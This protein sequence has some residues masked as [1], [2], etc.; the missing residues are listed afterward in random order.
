MKIVTILMG[1]AAFGLAFLIW[2][3][4]M[5]DQYVGTGSVK[6]FLFVILL[7]LLWNPFGAVLIAGLGLLLIGSAVMP[8]KKNDQT[9]TNPA[10]RRQPSRSPAQDSPAQGGPPS[11]GPT[12]GGP[13]QG[14]P[15]R[16]A[17]GSSSS[18][19]PSSS[20]RATPNDGLRPAPNSD[21]SER[22]R[23]DLGAPVP[24]DHSKPKTARDQSELE[25][26]QQAPDDSLALNKVDATKPS[27]I[28]PNATKPSAITPNAITLSKTV[29]A[30]TPAHATSATT[31]EPPETQT[32]RTLTETERERVQKYVQHGL[33]MVSSMTGRNDL[34]LSTELGNASETNAMKIVQ[35]IQT[36]LEKIKARKLNAQQLENAA[37]VIGT[38]WGEVATLAYG[39]EWRSN[40][41]GGFELVSPQGRSMPSSAMFPL[42]PIGLI[43]GILLGENP[44]EQCSELFTKI[45]GSARSAATTEQR[46]SEQ[47]IPGMS[48]SLT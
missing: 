16:S 10:P 41:A 3:F 24:S 1:L 39:C 29:P 31:N 5:H 40:P 21:T 25:H 2:N 19:A 43:R 45:L 48:F 35:D 26:K 6:F 37:T 9:S 20:A 11:Q 30:E 22:S 34:E 42:S 36:A 38:L 23:K 17:Q 28:T 12:P 33:R 27:T 47:D 4:P 13:A 8:E 32:H 7:Q 15:G 18:S 44:V 46:K 14:R